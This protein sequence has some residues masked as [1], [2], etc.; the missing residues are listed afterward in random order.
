MAKIILIIEDG[1]WMDLLPK[2]LQK[3]KE[4]KH[5]ELHEH[6]NPKEQTGVNI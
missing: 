1:R 2:Y 6:L 3:K 4:N 5:S